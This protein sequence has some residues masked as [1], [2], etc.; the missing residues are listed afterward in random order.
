M[1]LRCSVRGRAVLAAPHG[2]A[3][4]APSGLSGRSSCEFAKAVGMRADGV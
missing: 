4:G 1:L 3:A 2:P